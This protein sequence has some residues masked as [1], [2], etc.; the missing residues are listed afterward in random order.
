VVAV[1][2]RT[3][4]IALAAAAVDEKATGSLELHGCWATLREVLE[5]NRTMQ[6]MP[7]VFCFGLLEKADILHLAGLVAPRK[8]RFHEI[9]KR[10]E[11]ELNA[12]EG[13]Y[14]RLGVDHRPL[15]GPRK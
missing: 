7:E 2:P 12:L 10:H 13:L 4:L 8:V 1:G 15:V 14:R 9:T 6:Q 3:S 5:A 11:S